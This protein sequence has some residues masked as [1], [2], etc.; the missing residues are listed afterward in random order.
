MNKLET[1]VVPEELGI[2][3]KGMI[4]G[5]SCRY[6]TMI[7]EL[8]KYWNTVIDSPTGSFITKNKKEL[9][10]VIIGNRE[11]EVEG[12][13]KYY[14]LIKGHELIAD[15]GD[16]TFKYWKTDTSDGRVFPSHRL[17]NHGDFLI[18]MSKEDWNVYGINDSNADFVRVKQNN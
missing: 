17:I 5:E 3:L 11:Y 18:E 7:D 4:L 15:K 2:W 8:H 9:I 6:F 1:L 14:A 13:Q 16:W 12:E 10:E